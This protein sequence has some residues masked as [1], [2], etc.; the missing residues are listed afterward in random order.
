MDLQFLHSA[1]ERDFPNGEDDFDE[2]GENEEHLDR[3][4]GALN[5]GQQ[6]WLVCVIEHLDKESGKQ[7]EDEFDCEAHHDLLSK[8][9]RW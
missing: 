8:V 4:R 2:E 5:P 3:Q 1:I 7:I 6:A 9:K